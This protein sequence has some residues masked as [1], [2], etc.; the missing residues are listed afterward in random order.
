MYTFSKQLKYDSGKIETL[1]QICLFNALMFVKVWLNSPKT[2]DAP[3]ND[4]ML[5]DSLKITR[6]HS[7]TEKFAPGK[8]HLSSQ[9]NIW[10]NLLHVLESSLPEKPTTENIQSSASTADMHPETYAEKVKKGPHTVL[11]LYPA[12]N[13][14]EQ[15]AERNK[16]FSV[17]HLLESSIHPLKDKIKI[18]DVRKIRNQGLALDCEDDCDVQKILSSIQNQEELKKNITHVQPKGKLPKVIFYN[19]SNDIKE[20]ELREVIRLR[21]GVADETIKVKFK[22][23]ERREDTSHWVVETSPSTF[24]LLTKNKKILLNWTAYSVREFIRVKCQNFGHTQKNCNNNIS[25]CAFCSGRHDSRHCISDHIKCINCSLSNHYK[26]T[27]YDPRHTAAD[28]NCPC[29]I[30]EVEAYR[31]STTF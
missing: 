2:E 27:N 31:R 26:K 1:H 25:F 15:G 24:H 20:P 7:S 4:M 30:K 16:A 3:V 23:K 29:F 14:D 12:Q 8:I 21:S 18:K 10:R 28:G 13:T 22:L 5:W 6:N 17:K 11:L 9:K 19:I